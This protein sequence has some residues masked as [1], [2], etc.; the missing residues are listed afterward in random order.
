MLTLMQQ[1]FDSRRKNMNIWQDPGIK[2]EDLNVDVTGKLSN[3]MEDFNV[4]DT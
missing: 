3:N 1:E 4:D 2:N